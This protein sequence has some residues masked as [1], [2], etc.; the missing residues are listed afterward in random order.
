MKRVIIPSV[1]AKS[2][3][4]FEKII[5]K[6]SSHVKWLQLDVMDG[7]FVRNFSISFDFKLPKTKCRYEAHLMVKNPEEWIEEH[8][9][10]VDV[11]IFHIKS[12]KNPARVIELIMKKRKKVGI[13]LNPKI[14]IGE[15]K[16]YLNKVDMILFMTVYPG[17][18]GAKFLP[19]MLGKVREL[20]KLK[21]RL[22]IE[23]D[24][25]INIKTIKLASEA[26]ANRFVVGSYLQKSRNVKKAI[27]A[28]KAK[29]K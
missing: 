8:A 18:Y 2:Q 5:K 6:V 12:T 23:V 22:Q 28:L 11:V 21:P 10:K 14:K 16:Q 24:G 25:G 4:E 9:K 26:G 1:I 15:I 3:K 17:G 7:K 27:Q 29:V 20:R 13:A 19:K